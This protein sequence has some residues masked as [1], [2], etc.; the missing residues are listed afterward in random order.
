[1]WNLRY[2]I[3]EHRGIKIGTPENRLLTIENK[4]NV[5]GGKVHGE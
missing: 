2:K 4:L 5:A 1:M 3:D